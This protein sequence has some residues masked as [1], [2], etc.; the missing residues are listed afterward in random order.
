[1]CSTH[2]LETR[3]CL[4]EW[5]QERPAAMLLARVVKNLLFL[6]YQLKIWPAVIRKALVKP[7]VRHKSLVGISLDQFF[8]PINERG[9]E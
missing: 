6:L 2:S 4:V 9:Q 3:L 1:M 7:N 5:Q 8:P